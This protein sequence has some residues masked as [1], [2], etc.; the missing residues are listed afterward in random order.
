MYNKIVNS[1]T[2]FW[3][4]I[5]KSD[6]DF[7]DPYVNRY[8]T[9]FTNK[10]ISRTVYQTL[11]DD[12]SV[13]N[14]TA[15]YWRRKIPNLELETHFKTFRN[16]NRISNVTK[17]RNFQFKLLHN[18][19]F[20][21]NVLFHWKITDT[22][23]CEFCNEQKQDICHLIFYCKHFQAAESRGTIYKYKSRKYYLQQGAPAHYTHSQ[24][25]NFNYKICGIQM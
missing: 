5:C 20:C 25:N 17:L 24:S 21:N 4:T 14:K 3:K 8:E 23:L 12:D 13:L 18:K 9:I 10:C 19:I 2:P 22:Q 15:T 6:P 7:I 11:T 16:S 1:I